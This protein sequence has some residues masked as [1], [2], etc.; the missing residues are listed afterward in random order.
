MDIRVRQEIME[1]GESPIVCPPE[2]SDS[3]VEHPFEA[4]GQ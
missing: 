3:D 2:T 1:S 4:S